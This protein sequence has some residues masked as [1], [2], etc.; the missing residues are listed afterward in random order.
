MIAKILQ[1]RNLTKAYRRVVRNKGSAGV[2]GMGVEEL[3]EIITSSQAT[4]D[5][6]MLSA[7]VYIASLSQKNGKVVSELLIIQ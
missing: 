7:G 1:A 4:V 3:Q 5:I 2:D 6:S